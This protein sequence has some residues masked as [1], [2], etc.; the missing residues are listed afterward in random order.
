M[1]T[2]SIHIDEEALLAIE[3]LT[4]QLHHPNRFVPTSLLRAWPR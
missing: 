4:N 3:G 2:E 1:L